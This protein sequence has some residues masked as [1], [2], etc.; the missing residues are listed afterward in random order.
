V[1]K[2]P[3]AVELF[4]YGWIV[5]GRI[6]FG[7]FSAAAAKFGGWG[8]YKWSV[9]LTGSTIVHVYTRNDTVMGNAV[10]PR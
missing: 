10:I 3:A 6:F 1:E 8:V 2:N 5:T 4:F 7:G 9:M